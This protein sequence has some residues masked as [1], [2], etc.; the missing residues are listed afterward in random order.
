MFI[1]YIYIYIYVYNIDWLTYELRSV[2][3]TGTMDVNTE[4]KKAKFIS[5]YSTVILWISIL[6]HLLSCDCA[7]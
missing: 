5:K 1:I 7:R 3:L 4:V 6:Q 2:S